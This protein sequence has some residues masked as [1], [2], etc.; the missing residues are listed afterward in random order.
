MLRF[1][2]ALFLSIVLA[3]PSLAQQG[4]LIRNSTADVPN[5][6]TYQTYLFQSG[7][8]GNLATWNGSAW[9]QLSTPYSN[10]SSN[11]APTVSNDNTQGYQPGSL[12][13]NA[14]LSVLYI[15]TSAQTG[16]AVWVTAGL[17][18]TPAQGYPLISDTGA[19]G[20]SAFEPLPV[21]SIDS[22]GQSS[23]NVMVFNGTNWV[24][25]LLPPSSIAQ[26]GALTGQLLQWTGSA[27]TPE[28]VSGSGS[29]VGFSSGNLSPLFTTSVATSTTTPAQSFTLDNAAAN[30][31]YSNATS[32]SATPAFNE[33]SITAGTGLTGGGDLT[34][35]PTIS[36]NTPVLIANGG[37]GAATTGAAHLFGN[38][39]GSTA[40]PSFFSAG[41][42]DQLLGVA[43]S[44]GGLEGKTLTA[45]SGVSITPTAGAITIAA[46]G[47]GGTVT[48]VTLT[49]DGTVL[50]STPSSAVTT[51]GTLTAALANAGAASVLGNNTSGSAPPTYFSVGTTDQL[52]GVA[53]T[54]GG[55]EGKSIVGSGS[56]SVVNTAG[57]I[58]IGYSGGSGT[59]TSF[60]SGNLSPLFTT[61]V[62]TSTSTPALTYSLDNAASGTLFGNF[63]GGSTAPSFNAEG[64]NDQ[65]LGVVHSGTGLEYKTITAGTGVSVTP[66]SGAITIAATGGSGT[67]TSVTFTGD[68]TMLS[69]TPSSAVT[70]TGTLTAALNNAGA[71]SVWG[72][73]GGSTGSP[74][75]FS[76]GT[77]DQLLGVAHSG[78]GLEGK[79][80]A[81]GTGVTVTPTAGTITIAATGSGGTVTSFSAGNL[82]PLF[83]TSVSGA[84]TTPSLSF[85]LSN[86]TAA[87]LFGNSSG[88]TTTPSFFTVGT[89]DQVLGV[90]HT[91]G[92][93]EG[94][95]ITAGSGISV[96]PTA[97]AITIAAT[98]GSGT[99]T[100][101]TFTGDG[102][103]LSSTPSSAVTTSGT[104]TAALATAATHTILSN[105]TSGT[106]AP[107]YNALSVT[108]GTGLTGGGNVATSP[109][110]SLANPSAS[111]IGGVESLAA[112]SHKWINQIS[113]SGV[114]SATQPAFSDISGSLTPSQYATTIDFSRRTLNGYPASVA[115]TSL[116]AVG[117]TTNEWLTIGGTP[118]NSAYQQ[119]TTGNYYLTIGM[120]SA[121][122]SSSSAGIGNN[123]TNFTTL[124][125]GPIF[126]FV[127]DMSALTSV[128]YV[129]GVAD[130]G[131]SSHSL[132]TSD[133]PNFSYAEFRYS[134]NA[135]DTSYQCLVG[136]ATASYTQVS[137]GVAPSANTPDVFIIDCSAVSTI[138]FY[139]NGTQVASINTNVPTSTVGLYPLVGCYT[140]SSSARTV[141]T[142]AMTCNTY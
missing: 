46:T 134:T 88:G 40:A 44:G 77:T 43:H 94:K 119:G 91:G 20:G 35:S 133:T 76:V 120:A 80:I 111:T 55:L 48:S 65:V 114:P 13:Y 78:G 27:W 37:T 89:T 93:L 68:G 84:T 131:I 107:S 135:S 22:T 79:T 29:V 105:T 86:A 38:A 26:G 132:L 16:S 90:A 115:S 108:A 59:V 23:G 67:V 141:Y 128:R 47:S 2:L 30:T 66:S 56:I 95:T 83:T 96:T 63:S 4:V 25:E 3:A 33:L 24:G 45:G 101:V 113:T 142:G 97:G 10:F 130:A 7:N 104:L 1:L 112:V 12:W 122:S 124:Q 100:S 69:S 136:T 61:S 74:S 138:V 34:T 82:S 116:I 14:S 54:G 57:T 73:N 51:S 42:T 123:N 85:G 109:T 117:F 110:I 127:A 98:G 75:Y 31:I 102:T 41:T 125:A 118:Q 81:A 39:T 11:T 15:C 139:I 60:S 6:V 70:T 72:N 71:A 19:L 52:L 5:P 87:Q 17:E 8:Y 99:V 28:T 50:S 21:A 92:G 62:A 140:L 18:A 49:G 121:A 103:V 64:S 58:T 137:S 36:L 129:V 106:A 126:T 32:G 53:H 9:Q